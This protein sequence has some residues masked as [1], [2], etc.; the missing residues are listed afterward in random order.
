MGTALSIA[1]AAAT[2]GG[3]LFWLGAAG[4][5]MAAAVAFY[6]SEQAKKAADRE[7]EIMNDP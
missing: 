7:Y 5:A 3:P 1:A 4:L 2:L 6:N